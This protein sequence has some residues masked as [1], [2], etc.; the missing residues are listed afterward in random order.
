MIDGTF[1]TMEA[2]FIDYMKYIY[3][4]DFKNIK[5]N[6]MKHLRKAFYG[7]AYIGCMSGRLQRDRAE[8]WEKEIES[9]G[10]EGAFIHNLN[11]ARGVDG[12]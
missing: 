10:D 5:E 6:Q 11:K 12:D 3:A 4:D 1:G 8:K 7:G 9:Y 2:E